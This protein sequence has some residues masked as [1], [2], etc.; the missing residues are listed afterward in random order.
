M[1]RRGEETVRGFTVL[2]VSA[3]LRDSIRK[4][5]SNTPQLNRPWPS[6][7]TGFRAKNRVLRVAVNA[8]VC[9]SEE[10]ANFKMRKRWPA[11][12]FPRWRFGLVK[13]ACHQISPIGAKCGLAAPSTAAE[14]SAKRR[15]AIIPGVSAWTDRVVLIKQPASRGEN[16]IEHRFGQTTSEGVLLA[17]MV[18]AQEVSIAAEWGQAPCANLGCLPVCQ[19][20]LATNSTAACQPMCPSASRTRTSSR[21]TVASSQGG[22]WRF[23]RALVCSRAVR[24][25][26]WR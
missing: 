20:R 13:T 18:T 15:M 8:R 14:G 25:D 2:S 6:R 17:G 9:L 7:W 10:Y 12:V 3:P 22:S 21:S 1:A 11:L 4:L 19:L 23:P 26:T 5:K 24:N 16:R